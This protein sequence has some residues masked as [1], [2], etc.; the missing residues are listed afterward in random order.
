MNDA[1]SNVER[2]DEHPVCLCAFCMKAVNKRTV[3]GAAD[4]TVMNL[5]GGYVPYNGSFTVGSFVICTHHQIP[6][7][8]SNQGE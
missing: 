8:R 6:L 3:D 1:I 4:D 5:G 2:T 7:G